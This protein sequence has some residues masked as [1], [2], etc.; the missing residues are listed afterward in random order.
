[1]IEENNWFNEKVY[2]KYTYPISITL[3]DELIAKLKFLTE[4]NATGINT[5]FNVYFYAME[6]EHEAV[7]EIESAIGRTIE[8]QIRYGFEEFPNFSKKLAQL[9]LW[10][11][12]LVAETMYQHAEDRVALSYPQTDYVFSQVITPELDTSTDQW[13]YFEGIVNNYK[14][15]AFL[16]NEYDGGTDEQINRNVIQPLPCILYL[17][18]T[19]FL[20]AGFTLDGDILTD[21]EFSKASLYT[22]SK[23]YSSIT[24]NGKQELLVDSTEIVD[25]INSVPHYHKELIIVEPGRY[26]ISGNLYVKKWQ[27]NGQVQFG[28]AQMVFDNDVV[29]NWSTTANSEFFLVDII[30]E[31]FSG[32]SNLVLEFDSVQGNL[33]FIG[34]V[35]VDDSV[36]LDISVVQLAAYDTDGT[37]IPT[38]ISPNEIDLTKCVPDKTFGDLYN[39]IKG[40]KNYDIDITGDVVTI[41]LVSNQIGLGPKKDLQLFEVKTP[42]RIFNQ[43]KSFELKFQDVQSDDYTFPSIYVDANGIHQSPYIKKDETQEITIDAIALPL[44]QFGD[45]LTADGFIDDSSKFQIILYNGLVGGSNYT[46]NPSALTLVNI[47][48]IY[49]KDWI[50]FLLNAIGFKWKFNSFYEKIKDL[51][52]KSTVFAYGQFHVVRK[53]TRRNVSNS[54]MQ[55]DIETESID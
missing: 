30:V 21:P 5:I 27:G 49:Y 43:G 54:I 12:D 17:L 1:M 46:T 45:A 4:N 31:V 36:I 29:G 2:S 28:A 39:M 48:P 20:D 9:P 13:A 47:Y 50:D 7:F 19:G 34:G 6:V 14:A 8:A 32:E 55:T 15:G 35:W 16:I 44:K 33:E 53:I 52:I 18:K 26:K 51:T 41:N 37:L 42:E 38:L 25:Y 23:F 10:K 40:W 3:S 11:F 24:D 22:L